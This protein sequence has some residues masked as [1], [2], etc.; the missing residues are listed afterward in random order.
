MGEVSYSLEKKRAIARFFFFYFIYGLYGK[1]PLLEM[2]MKVIRMRCADRQITALL[3]QALK[4]RARISLET[5]QLVH[6]GLMPSPDVQVIEPNKMDIGDAARII[7]EISQTER[8]PNILVVRDTQE[9]VDERVER[10]KFEE[11][12]EGLGV[13]VAESNQALVTQIEEDMTEYPED[14][15]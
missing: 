8:K 6:E 11:V 1:L 10:E 13:K 7:C 4:G 15:A 9:T 14:D 12:L 2:M 3:G 5:Q